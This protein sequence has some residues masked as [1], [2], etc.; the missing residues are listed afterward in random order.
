MT[1][2]HLE[3]AVISGYLLQGQLK[4]AKHLRCGWPLTGEQLLLKTVTGFLESLIILNSEC[5]TTFQ[6]V[7]RVSV[8]GGGF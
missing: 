7:T 2:H 1:T 6:E 3:L 8:G 4:L 5:K